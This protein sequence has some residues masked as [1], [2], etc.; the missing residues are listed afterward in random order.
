[1]SAD[2]ALG[3]AAH[4]DACVT[5][6]VATLLGGARG[7][8]GFGCTNRRMLMG[9][10][11]G[12][13][14]TDSTWSALRGCSRTIASGATQSGCGDPTGGGCYAER[15]GYRFSGPG[16][17]YEGLVRM[18]STGAR[19]TGKV[20]LVD[21]HLLDPIR[22]QRARRIFTTSV[23][24]PFHERFSNETIAIVF[25]VMAAT[26]RHAHQCLT[27]RIRRGREWFSWVEAA[28]AKDGVSPAAFCFGVMRQYVEGCDR[29]SDA[30][31][32]LVRR[33]IVVESARS[34]TW[35]LLNV[36]IGV[37]VENQDAADERIPDLIATPAAVRFLSCEPLLGPVNLRRVRPAPVP[38]DALTGGWG[39][40]SNNDAHHRQEPRLHWVIAGC[41]S[42]PGARPCDVA[43]LRSL[44][45]QCAAAGMPFFL[46][47]ARSD[48]L[49]HPAGVQR[50]VTTGPGSKRKA[51]GIIELPY[52]DGV[53]HAA[54][55]EVSP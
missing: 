49:G 47:Q 20:L 31:R 30:D 21:N 23:S 1:M 26:V 38:I 35:P 5:A 40:A 37:S 46:K 42:G 45:D 43:W 14:W 2:T 22:W 36:W 18:T 24:D 28:A 52:L 13:S 44:R 41:E 4:A 3:R 39:V 29:F 12:I 6:L 34:A 27:K 32:A 51:G 53:Q 16:L 25:G 8:H 48:E 50:P 10:K 9:S 33:S 7:E 19:W 17:P 11:T 15:N 54:F 55:P